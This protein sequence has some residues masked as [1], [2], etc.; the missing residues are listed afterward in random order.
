MSASQKLPVKLQRL[1]VRTTFFP[2]AETDEEKVA[3]YRAAMRRGDKFPP[4]RVVD[5]GGDFLIIDGHHRIEAAAEA[6][7]DIEALVVDG[8][9]FEDFD[10]AHRHLGVRADDAALWA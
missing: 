9:A 4:V 7:F 5:Y 10:A 1:C 6:G 3:A 2:Q 8:E